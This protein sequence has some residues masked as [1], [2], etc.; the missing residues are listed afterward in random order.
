M[1]QALN[2]TILLDFSGN[3]NCYIA[4]SGG[5][6]QSE[7]PTF[8]DSF[9]KNLNIIKVCNGKARQDGCVPDYSD[10]VPD[11]NGRC[12]GY[13][14]NWINNSDTVYVVADGQIIITYGVKASPI[15]LVD[16]NGFKGPN[17]YG[18]DLFGFVF[19]SKAKSIYLAP[20]NDCTR[21]F[22]NSVSNKRTTGQMMKYALAG[23]N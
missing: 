13:N 22:P 11:D 19:A 4:D 15:M 9:T 23:L 21:N 2:K 5:V 6:F 1:S 16:I 18:Y 10:Y 3:I 14:Q 17:K 20:D 12:N 7:C 8:F